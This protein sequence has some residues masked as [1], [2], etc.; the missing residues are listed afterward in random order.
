V[1]MATVKSTEQSTDWRSTN[2]LLE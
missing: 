1:E 2:R